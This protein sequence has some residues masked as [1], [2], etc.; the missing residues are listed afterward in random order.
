[1]AGAAFVALDPTYPEARL[2]HI[3][4]NARVQVL[5]TQQA[6]ADKVPTQAARILIDH[7]ADFAGE[8]EREL[9]V[10]LETDALAYV[11]YTS[12]STGRPKG[13][14]MTHEALA[15]IVRYQI[16]SANSSAPRTLQ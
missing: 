2:A 5:L 15:N 12:G 6:V 13:I 14:A 4:D 8:S 10:H 7:L 11:I 16:T 3:L 9:G 1:K